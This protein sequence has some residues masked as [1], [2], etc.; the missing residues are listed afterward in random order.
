M[1]I[2]NNTVAICLATYNGEKYIA[3][4]LDSIINQ[5][6]KDFHIFIRDDGSSDHTV[7]IL[8]EYQCKH[9]DIISVIKDTRLK[10]GSSKENFASILK[11]I[12]EKY[13]F[14]YFMFSDQDDIWL[15]DKIQL[16]MTRI[17]EEEQKYKG[18][19][20][21]HS[22]LKVV[23]ENLYILGESFFKYRAL[24]VN[25]KDINH[26]L[27]QNNVTGCTML[28]NKKQ[29]DIIDISNNCVAMHDWWITLTAATFGRIVYISKPTILYRQHGN[30]VVGATKVNTIGF[31]IKRLTGSAH[32]RETLELSVVQAQAF[33]NTYQ[34]EM[35]DDQKKIYEVYSD[36][37]NHNKV[38]KIIT[39]FKYKFLKQGIVQI[40]GEMM[41]I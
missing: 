24:N 17:K 9:S 22:D 39:I 6:Y 31:I 10:G 37:L 23:D 11:W 5:K 32:V 27:V 36:L 20:L 8:N 41:F 40:I 34:N 18:P 28:W 12:S 35:S 3:E 13:N 38:I 25:K 2:G 7:E 19:I 29:N 33:L 14:N 1:N 16:G 30:N 4:Q 15:D 21:V 26:I